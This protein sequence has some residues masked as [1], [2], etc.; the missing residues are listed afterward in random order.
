MKPEQPNPEG[1]G[2][3]TSKG[4]NSNFDPIRNRLSVSSDALL[5]SPAPQGYAGWKN[6]GIDPLDAKWLENGY[7]KAEPLG[8]DE[9][10]LQAQRRRLDQFR[11]KQD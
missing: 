10:V 8:P 5:S 9:T 11:G 1:Q 2:A 7:E 4:D 3:D 6:L